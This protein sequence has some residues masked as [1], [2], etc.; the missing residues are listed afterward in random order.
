ML[1][2]I[3]TPLSAHPL[4]TFCAFLLCFSNCFLFRVAILQSQKIKRGGSIGYK[5]WV[6]SDVLGGLHYYLM[7][8][9]HILWSA[10]IWGNSQV[11]S[12]RLQRMAG[13]KVIGI[14][15]AAQSSQEIPNQTGFMLNNPQKNP[16]MSK[17]YWC[18]WVY[19]DS[20]GHQKDSAHLITAF[21]MHCV[22]IKK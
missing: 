9:H 6:W 15:M 13:I 2:G 21:Q 18:H 1:N 11:R 16:V 19:L 5:V 10:E 22:I 17:C 20:F 8:K 12:S 3:I 7:I 14:W 4:L